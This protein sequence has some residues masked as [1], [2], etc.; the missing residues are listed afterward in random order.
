MTTPAFA[1]ILGLGASPAPNVA[2]YAGII[3]APPAL[4]WQRDL[5]GVPRLVPHGRPRLPGTDRFICS[6]GQVTQ[7]I[8]PARPAAPAGH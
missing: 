1:A 3:D 5:P 6:F 7:I 2:D 4:I 8:S